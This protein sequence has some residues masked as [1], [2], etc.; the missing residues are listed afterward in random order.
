MIFSCDGRIGRIG[1]NIGKKSD[2]Q[3]EKEERKKSK[4]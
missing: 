2:K 3:R 4:M 1:K